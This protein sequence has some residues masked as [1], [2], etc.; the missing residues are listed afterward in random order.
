MKSSHLF[1]LLRPE[2]VKTNPVPLCSDAFSN[3]PI[4]NIDDFNNDAIDATNRLELEI[5]PHFSQY[6]EQSFWQESGATEESS[7]LNGQPFRV[8]KTEAHRRGIN[9]RCLGSI[10][11]LVTSNVE[12]NSLI[13]TEIVART[14]RSILK[15]RMRNLQA[16][17]EQRYKELCLNFFNSLF[18][19]RHPDNHSTWHSKSLKNSILKRF[20]SA[21]GPEERSESFDL[22]G[23]IFVL[24]LFYRLQ[25]LMG[26]SFTIVPEIHIAIEQYFQPNDLSVPLLG[27]DTPTLMQALH[28]SIHYI[29][30]A[31]GTALSSQ[32]SALGSHERADQLYDQAE[33][34]FRASLEA[35]PDDFRA[36]HNLV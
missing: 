31:E 36:L 29:D 4:E 33:E 27:P 6:L 15:S 26:I 3:W 28:K 21:V 1:R 18:D 19:V 34:K 22:R 20:L 2:L 25:E 5:I 24:P 12:V 7:L 32:A 11:N 10:R 16:A 17:D 23:T 8:L 9:L 14:C 35:K 13:M 30:F